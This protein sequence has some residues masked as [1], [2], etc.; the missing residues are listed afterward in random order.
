[1]TTPI[2]A[3]PFAGPA[4]A[5]RLERAAAALT[6][7]G[8]AVEILDAAAAART[9]IE[10]LI[11]EGASVFTG[12]SETLRLSGIDAHINTSGRYQAV[13]PRLLAMDRVT[14]AGDI[15][16]L[17]ASPGVAVGSV[18][19]L[20]ETG[21]LVVASASGSQ[22]P[23]YAGGAARAI[24]IGGAQK[25][26]PDL[27]AALRRVEDH[28][29]APGKRPRPGGLRAS[30]RH[31][32]PAHPQ[33]GTPP[34]AR[35]RPAAAPS[36]RIL[37]PPG[38]IMSRIPGRTSQSVPHAAS[39][40]TEFT[41]SHQPAVPPAPPA[42]RPRRGGTP[43]GRLAGHAKDDAGVSRRAA[44]AAFGWVLAFLAWHVVWAVTGLAFPQA[45]HHHGAA[46]MLFWT[47]DAITVVMW[48]VGIPLPLALARPWGRRVPRWMLLWAAWIGCALLGA[49]GI[50][51]VADEVARAIG[52]SRGLTGL[53]AAQAMGTGH[54]S[55]WLSFAGVATEVLFVAGGLVF[56]LAALT[57]QRASRALSSRPAQTLV[58][59]MTSVMIAVMLVAPQPA[60]AVGSELLALAV[61][62][63]AAL[64][65]L[66]QRAGQAR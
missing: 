30:Q 24:W 15:R 27:P 40:L 34:R 26:V 46:L 18:A 6:A 57:Y 65:I 37:K 29:L 35:H 22:L 49:R 58:L 66:D 21:S 51:G 14:G 48:A 8:F 56:G 38:V 42:P 28:A 19:A 10:D 5:E 4:P 32:P 3:T 62:A 47:S 12:A 13:R 25:V 7:H 16:R 52:F 64:F 2:P 53:T 33:R 50:A 11:P 23:G 1:M 44:Y 17:L 59:F 55:A 9:R 61:L 63:A 43:A 39:Q 20:T 60:T 41:S 45:S 31:Q 36:H 54:P